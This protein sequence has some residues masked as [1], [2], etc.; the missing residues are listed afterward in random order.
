MTL[1]D[2]FNYRKKDKDNEY[3]CCCEHKHPERGKYPVNII[4]V[5]VMNNNNI[6]GIQNKTTFVMSLGKINLYLIVHRLS[7]NI[8]HVLI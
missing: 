7:I 8:F 6:K 4:A 5:I 1:G 3:G 2:F